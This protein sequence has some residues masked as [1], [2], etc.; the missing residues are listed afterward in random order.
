MIQINIFNDKTG[1][2]DVAN[3]NYE[4]KLPGETLT[5]KIRGFKR[6]KGWAALVRKIVECA[7]FDKA[8]GFN[9]VI[10]ELSKRQ[11]GR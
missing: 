2:P 3:Y 8:I 4:I 5:G 6:H 10:H 7:E 1:N 11:Y 9:D